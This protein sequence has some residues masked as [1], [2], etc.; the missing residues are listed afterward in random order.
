MKRKLKVIIPVAIILI[1]AIIIVIAVFAN[2]SGD[3][4]SRVGTEPLEPKTLQ[5]YIS[6]SGTIESANSEQIYSKLQ[7][8][9][10]ALNVS[11]GDVVKKDDVLAT[12]DSDDIRENITKA[13]EQIA[14][15]DTNSENQIT[16]AE[17]NYNNALKDYN[18]GVNTQVLSAKRQLDNATTALDR[19]K[20]A[21]NDALELQTMDKSTQLQTVNR[22]IESAQMNYD[23]ALKKLETADTDALKALKD[24]YDDANDDY[25]AAIGVNDKWRTEIAAAQ[26]AY[27]AAL[28]AYTQKSS[29]IATFAP[30]ESLNTYISALTTAEANLNAILDKYDVEDAFDALT[31]AKLAYDNAHQ[32][33]EDAVK[34]AETA[35]A[36]AKTQLQ[37]V[38]DGT[39]DGITSATNALADAELNYSNALRDYN[40]T[41]ESVERNL[42]DLKT[43]AERA[44]INAGFTSSQEITL[45]NLKDQLDDATLTAPIDG[46]VTY[47]NASEGDTPEG[48]M[49]TVE[50]TADLK[51]TVL[52][53][54]YDIANIVLGMNCEIA[55]NADPDTI[56]TGTVTEIAPTTQKTA[57]GVDA[58]TASF[59]VEV[60]VTSKETKLNI[61]MTAQV[62]LIYEEDKDVL[63]VSSDLVQTDDGGKFVFKAVKGALEN[64]TAKKVY[65]TTGMETDFY[66]SV[67]PVTAGELSQGDLI[68]TDT[69]GLSDGA[70]VQLRQSTANASAAGNA[71]ADGF[72]VGM[73]NG[74]PPAGAPPM[75]SKYAVFSVN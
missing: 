51:M 46:I 19:T 49:F 4:V 25:L 23:K 34:N 20:T 47:V 36:N 45:Q 57:L 33:L 31:A 56:Y 67:T 6:V 66:I 21:Y 43:A 69:T 18:D 1:I 22:S 70:T 60:A 41:V 14:Q 72:A 10:D 73:S 27:Q 53:S 5:N 75:M 28:D 17:K 26:K 2:S 30:G 3:S 62:K 29:S 64:Y 38:T 37:S 52:V 8:P 39:D 61:G 58:G 35:L 40:T 9:V 15:S 54:E 50:D 13:E 24:A 12:L 55:P 7:L 63:A 32:D 59:E 74:A 44:K 68:I 48:I 42:S 11:V 71:F 16:D 65:V